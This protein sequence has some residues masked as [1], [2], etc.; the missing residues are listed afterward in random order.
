MRLFELEQKFGSLPDKAGVAVLDW[1]KDWPTRDGKTI[2]LPA[3][4]ETQFFPLRDG[5]Q[6]LLQIPGRDCA[7][8]FFG[9]TDE[10]PFLVELDSNVVVSLHIGEE[11][12]FNV[13]KPNGVKVLEGAFDTKAVRQG[14][15]FAVPIPLS[16]KVTC[17]MIALVDSDPTVIEPSNEEERK[18]HLLETRHSLISERHI[19]MWWNDNRLE[20][21]LVGEGILRA[22]NRE[23]RVLRGPHMFFRTAHLVNPCR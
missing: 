10:Q 18:V 12:F 16:W 19:R 8:V 13:I 20:C 15:W 14:D 21:V 3:Y 5:A 4:T 6:F 23:D 22:P 9:G 1:G 17:G 2:K 7:R 11:E